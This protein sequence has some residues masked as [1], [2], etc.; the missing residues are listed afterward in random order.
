ML[1]GEDVPNILPTKMAP[2]NCL[3]QAEIEVMLLGNG[4]ICD[5]VNILILQLK[6]GCVLCLGVAHDDELCSRIAM[7]EG[8]DRSRGLED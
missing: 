4:Q 2:R 8:V 6:P 7:Q 3:R 5:A 1:G